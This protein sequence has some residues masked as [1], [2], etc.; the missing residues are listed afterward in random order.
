MGFGGFWRKRD[1]QVEVERDRVKRLVFKSELWKQ[2]GKNR[3][4]IWSVKRKIH[5]CIPLDL[6][7]HTGSLRLA[8]SNGNECEH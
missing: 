8:P 6:D 2:T 7:F 5:P 3:L 4:R 1:A